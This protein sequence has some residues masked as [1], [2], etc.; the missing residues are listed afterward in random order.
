[1]E[2]ITEIDTTNCDYNAFD[3][4]MSCKELAHSIDLSNIIIDNMS[5]DEKEMLIKIIEGIRSLELEI[6]HQEPF[7]PEAR[8]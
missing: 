4:I 1:M 7:K 3:I 6:I 2:K 5:I 8:A